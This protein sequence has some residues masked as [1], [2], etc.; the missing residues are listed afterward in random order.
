MMLLT[1]ILVPSLIVALKTGFVSA[2]GTYGTSIVVDDSINR[3]NATLGVKSSSQ[4]TAK[5]TITNIGGVSLANL[6]TAVNFIEGIP[7]CMPGDFSFEFSFDCVAWSPIHPSEVKVAGPAAAPMQVE[8]VIGPPGGQTLNPGQSI[9]LYLRMTFINDLTPVWWANQYVQSII[10]WVFEDL[11][12][13]RH[14][15]GPPEMLYSQPP[16]AAGIIGWDNPVRID[17]AIMHT[18]EID[19]T[20]KFYYSVQ[21]AINAANPGDTIWVYDGTY[22]EALYISKSL[23][24][25]AASAPVIQ[26][27][28]LWATNYG[29]RKATIF[30][31]NAANVILDGLDV[32]GQGL[33]GAKNYAIIYENSGGTI[34]KC[35]SSPN[36]IGDMNSA[37]I[38][39][40]DNSDLTIES[41]VI[42]NFGRIG[43]YSNNAT[44]LIKGNT[45]IGQ[46]YSLDNLVNY[47][48]EIE[49]YTGPSKAEITGN[50]I[51]N[52]DNT[53]PSPQWSSAAIIVDIWRGWYD[54]LSSNV[55]I[56]GNKIHHNF[57]AI[58]VTA[59]SI[60]WAHY[61]CIRDNRYGVY[62]NP[63]LY[64]NN[65]TFD[66]RFNWWGD[67]G[68][69]THPSNPGGLGDSVGDYVLFDPWLKAYFEYSRMN[70][71]VG[72][73]VTFD[74]SLSIQCVRTIVSYTWNFDDGN[75]TTTTNPIIVH[76]FAALGTYNVTLTLTYDDTTTGT[77]WALVYVARE[78]YFKISPQLS[79]L[80][81]LNKTFSIN[82]TMNDLDVS[83]R[84][85][86]PQFRLCYDA[87]LLQF[88]NIAEGPFM[89]QAGD[90]FFI[91]LVESD[92][93]FGPNVLVG[94]LV[95]PDENGTWTQFPQGSGV[96][97]TITFKAIYQE[98]GLEKSPV[99]CDLTLNDTLLVDDQIQ[100]V[101]HT[102]QNGIYRMH[103]TNIA[104]INYDGKVDV[105]D[106]A[107]IAVA[108]GQHVGGPRWDPICDI[109]PDGKINVKD[110]ALVCRNYGWRSIYDP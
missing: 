74:A 66:A 80:G 92:G 22:N 90:T 99:S 77:E 81:L 69:P 60:S 52:C 57:E 54:L 67:S 53:H 6:L 50:E 20:G 78:P 75:T 56:K 26:G 108:F 87:T 15:D 106:V 1:I 33:S 5:G 3:V 39:A 71:V 37:A 85:V 18:A 40:W 91:S 70:P 109:V 68:G 62:V 27:G 9:T 43:I 47:G 7:G 45:I 2:S 95:Y 89:K 12:L 58:E 32:E 46:I 59:N 17:L 21:S 51:Y 84:V 36:T 19:G 31:E 97:A 13:N 93:E 107:R 73:P 30:V 110:V 44:L 79:E 4:V 23:T 94:I 76:A 63:D 38:A 82:I 104:D 105:K 28:Q 61:N 83:Q 48:I 8:L 102:T 96:L 72:E 98:R 49:D 101:P 88:I 41:C 16:W 10:A 24:I 25:K 86:M 35:V 29:N 103:P 14:W 42:K 65:V 34:Q 64:N 100:E 55:T 11:N